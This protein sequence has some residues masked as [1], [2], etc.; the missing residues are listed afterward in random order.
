MRA[1][2]TIS[3]RRTL[4][5][6][7]I[8]RSR[9]KRGEPVYLPPPSQSPIS[10]NA[11]ALIWRGLRTSR[12]YAGR[13]SLSGSLRAPMRR[14]NLRQVADITAQ[15][16]V[17]T[18]TAHTRAPPRR[19]PRAPSRTKTCRAQTRPREFGPR[20][21]QSP[22]HTCAPPVACKPCARPSETREKSKSRGVHSCTIAENS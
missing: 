12:H 5:F 22:T 10:G 13:N 4:F 8:R 21:A 3:S 9:T 19:H 6:A 11:K 20:S 17:S 7:Q 16:A 2:L 14:R 1:P 15:C 18:R